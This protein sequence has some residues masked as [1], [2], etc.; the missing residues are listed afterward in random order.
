MKEKQ[1]RSIPK[2]TYFG[3]NLKFLRRIKGLSQSDLAKELELTRSKIA[4]YESGV[5][6]PKAMLFLK[7]SQYFNVE[8][9]EMLNIIF[10]NH[11]VEHIHDEISQSNETNS[12]LAEILEQYIEKTNELTKIMNAYKALAEL[13]QAPNDNPLLKP[14]KR[15]HDELLEL[16]ELLLS[17]NWDLI[18]NIVTVNKDE[19]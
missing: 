10:T 7:I 8:P 6:E 12:Q 18:S 19:N 15:A 16:F 9:K 17:T 1:K 4:S 11:I 2:S 13:R 14:L 5:V 3:V